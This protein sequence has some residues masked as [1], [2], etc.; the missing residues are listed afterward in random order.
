MKSDSGAGSKLLIDSPKS[1]TV[2]SLVKKFESEAISHEPKNLNE[3]SNLDT[4]KMDKKLS[5]SPSNVGNE[6]IQIDSKDLNSSIES[7]DAEL[8][9]FVSPS[10]VKSDCDVSPMNFPGFFNSVKMEEG[11]MNVLSSPVLEFEKDIAQHCSLGEKNAMMTFWNC[12][13]VNEKEGFVHGL[14]FTKKKYN[15][16]N[17]PEGSIVDSIDDVKR[18]SLV[19]QRNELL[20][21]WKDLSSKKKEKVFHKLC[22]SKMKKKVEPNF[23]KNRI[24][25][26][27]SSTLFPAAITMKK[28]SEYEASDGLQKVGET[29]INLF[30]EGDPNLNLDEPV[31]VD[32]INVCSMQSLVKDKKR[33]K[34]D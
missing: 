5:D 2:T 15:S 17:E 29:V 24:P 25:I 10:P 30:P 32:L 33:K 26:K 34:K 14:R 22:T 12:L 4:P 18:I 31:T 19:S 27:P 13:T 8:K 21:N 7:D 3:V 11:V 6:D 1:I 16:G 9:L 20:L 23:G 28:S